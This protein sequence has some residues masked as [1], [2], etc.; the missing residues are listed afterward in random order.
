MK[1]RFPLGNA[2]LVHQFVQ[3][4]GSFVAEVLDALDDVD[5]AFVAR[6]TRSADA[7]WAVFHT[8]CKQ[9]ILPPRRPRPREAAPPPRLAASHEESRWQSLSS[10]ERVASLVELWRRTCHVYL[11]ASQEPE[12][13]RVRAALERLVGERAREALEQWVFEEVARLRGR[14]IGPIR[15]ASES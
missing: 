8:C 3:E 5:P 14:P 12:E 11:G 4:K 6:F 7:L 1:N 15:A 2:H 9:G 13:A 10:D